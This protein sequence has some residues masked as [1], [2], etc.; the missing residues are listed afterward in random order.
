MP[1]FAQDRICVHRDVR[2][3]GA[4]KG[5][6]VAE[7]RCLGHMSDT[8]R[9]THLATLGPEADI[10][11]RGVTFTYRLLEQ[12]LTALKD[13]EGRTRIGKALF[14]RAIFSEIADFDNTTFTKVASFN[15]VMFDE[16]AHF[17]SV[18]FC[19]ETFFNSS[20]F[21]H[22]AWFALTNFRRNV[23]FRKTRFQQNATFLQVS[24]GQA[25]IFDHA[26]FE[27]S[28]EFSQATIDLS[29]SFTHAFVEQELHIEALAMRIDAAR[30]RGRGRVRLRLRAAMVDLTDTALTGP[31]VVHGLQDSIFRTCEDKFLDPTSGQIPRVRVQSLRGVDAE[32]VTLTDVDLRACEFTGMHRA[33]RLALE[34]DCLFA[35][36]P[37]GRRRVLLEEHYWRAQA[38]KRQGKNLGGWQAAPRYVDMVGPA[39][40]EVMYRQLRKALEDGKNEPGA[41]DF[42]YGEMEMRRAVAKQGRRID[43]WLLNAYW[44]TSG[45]ALRVRRALTCLT[46]VLVMAVIALTVWGFPARDKNIRVDGIISNAGTVQ[47]VKVAVYQ[48]EATTR[49]YD[50]AEKATEVTLNAV[51]FHG[52]DTDLT[53]TGR[54]VD[55]AARLLGPLFLGFSALAIRNR[56]KR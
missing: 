7:G 22:E 43:Y 12:L 48:P 34:G 28:V 27:R 18:E 36:D 20:T 1:T 4:C 45:Y 55:I 49:V 35:S 46:I 3:G 9:A 8:D 5:S 10:D 50:R 2:T 11:A 52:T 44:A 51:I 53:T 42:Y 23:H 29:M 25:A 56:L 33:D 13:S 47:N 32:S 31:L 6:P 14:D 37:R 16:D 54:Y 17:A 39:R 19:G 15:D 26:T 21:A 24:F 41:A 40:L 38:K 30:L